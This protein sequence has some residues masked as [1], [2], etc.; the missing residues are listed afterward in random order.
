M[1]FGEPLLVL[2]LRFLVGIAAGL[3]INYFADV[4]PAA[5]RLAQ[6]ACQSCEQPLPWKAYLLGRR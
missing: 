4:L 2:A 1:I 3:I 5:R 6:P